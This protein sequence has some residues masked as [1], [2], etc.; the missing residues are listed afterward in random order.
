[1]YCSVCTHPK[2][3][4]IIKDYIYSGSLRNTA[5]KFDIGYRSLQRHI[6]LCIASIYS[7]Y[8]EKEYQSELKKMEEL[9][10]L[11]FSFQQMK[12]RPRSI[13][14]KPVKFTWSRRSWKK[15]KK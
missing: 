13:I 12:P 3:V 8:E 7:E 4:E 11:F 14:K 1:M 6:D 10:R 2:Q 5:L 9:L 15:D